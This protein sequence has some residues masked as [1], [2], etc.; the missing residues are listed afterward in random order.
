MF[1]KRNRPAEPEPPRQDSG[2]S[3][4]GGGPTG[5]PPGEAK[6]FPWP[7][8]DAYAACNLASGNIANNLA[9]WVTMQDGRVHAETYVATAGAI[10]GYAAQQSLLEQNPSAELHVVTTA[11]GGKYLF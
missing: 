10:A 8:D 3:A 11:S 1:G 9:A 7:N 5:T 6:L 2:N 4:G